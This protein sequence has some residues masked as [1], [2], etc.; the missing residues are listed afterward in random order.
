M[1]FQRHVKRQYRETHQ[2]RTA[3][4]RR[5]RRE[6]EIDFPLFAVEIAERQIPVDQ[7]IDQLRALHDQQQRAARSARAKAWIAA[8]ARIS[9]MTAPTGRAVRE[10]WNRRST[11]PANPDALHRLITRFERGQVKV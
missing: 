4:V 11:Y 2:K 6:V 10:Y 8:R 9:A 1:R 7:E 5:Q 3:I